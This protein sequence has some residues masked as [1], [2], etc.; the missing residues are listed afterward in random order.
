MVGHLVASAPAYLGS[1]EAALR[2]EPKPYLSREERARNIE[3]YG[4][5][6]PAR[7][8]PELR[9]AT[10]QFERAIAP[11]DQRQLATLA[12][13]GHGMRSVDWFVDQRLA[14]MAVHRWDVQ[15]T[16]GRPAE[17]TAPTATH[18]L[19]MLIEVN[20]P[21][22]QRDGWPRDSARVRLRP[23]ELA[24]ES[25]LVEAKPG[26][27]R[28]QPGNDGAVDVELSGPAAT[29]VLLLYQRRTSE[30]LERSGLRASGDAGLAARWAEIF[31]G[32]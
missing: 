19:P 1:I 2:G 3:E 4:A 27:L 8:L 23:D 32:P 18:L 29:M 6:P 28:V 12:P 16:L 10:D 31:K 17:L 9:E 20:L 15:T 14:E 13:H 21:A 25:W 22:I 24:G 26:E 5:R 30:Q 7:L 11:L